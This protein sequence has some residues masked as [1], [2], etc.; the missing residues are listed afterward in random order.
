MNVFQLHKNIMSDYKAYI[1]SFV[2]ISNDRIKDRVTNE[3]T[4][5]KLW[6][7]PLIQ[8]NPSFRQGKSLKNL[9]E[10]GLMH[11]ELNNVFSGYTLYD[12]QVEAL[13]IGAS[14]KDFIV[15]SGTGSGKS[16]TYISTIFDHL[17]KTGS[18]GQGVK[19]VIVYPMNALINSQFGEFEKFAERYKKN[20]N[21][22]FP[23]K[24][25]KYTGQESADEKRGTIENPPD[26][27]LTNYVMLELLLTRNSEEKLR[28]N[29]F[30]HLKYLVFDELHTYR[31]RQGSDVA[32]L[33]RKLQS[34]CSSVPICIG[35]SATMASGN[36]WQDQQELIAQV[37]NRFFAKPFTT[38]QIIGE[39][40]DKVTTGISNHNAVAN[41]LR[42][43]QSFSSIND[44]ITN[45]LSIL[46]ESNIILS[47]R[48]D[49]YFRAKPETIGSIVSRLTEITDIDTDN[50]ENYF[51]KYL[52]ELEIFNYQQA[53]QN[54]KSFFPF[55]IHQF[56][57]QTGSVYATL[58]A[59]SYRAVELD[60]VA[61]TSPDKGAK[62][63]YQIVFSRITGVDLY[64][65]E[66]D[67]VSNSYKTRIFNTFV[68]DEKLDDVGYLVIQDPAKEPF[69]NSTDDLEKLP[70]NWIEYD[71]NGTPRVKKNY[72]QRLPQQTY[73]N[74]YGQ[75]SER[76]KNGYIEVWFIPFKSNIDFTSGTVYD[77][78]TRENTMYSSLG[79][80]GRSTSTNI[81]VFSMIRQMNAI[82]MEKAI[83]KVLSFTDNRQD[84]A[85]QSGHFNDFIR[86]G[87]LRSAIWKAISIHGK[88]DASDI[89]DKTFDQL[90]LD[91]NELSRRPAD[92]GTYVYDQNVNMI[93]L[94]LKY[95]IISDLKRG[96]RVILPN[97]EQ[98]ALLEIDY[99]DL[100]RVIN[101]AFWDNHPELNALTIDN[102]RIL[103]FQLL[104]AFRKSS[105]IDFQFL[106]PVELENNRQKLKDNLKPGWLFSEDEE[107]G[108]SVKIRIRKSNN[109]GK[110]RISIS[111]AASGSTIGRFIKNIL[112]KAINKR[113]YSKSEYEDFAELLFDFLCNT[114]LFVRDDRSVDVPLYQLN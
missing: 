30:D 70:E 113:F 50:C 88:S 80:E 96:W 11:S 26:V 4:E 21:K 3:L 91:V 89:V 76:P 68:D 81:L 5:G 84:T 15:V 64:C 95:K 53:Q 31:G 94:A 104:D 38:S 19:A 54:K 33:I 25:S 39:Y 101:N 23:F 59:F 24:V 78:R 8:F 42:N 102:R 61:R 35:T 108:H 67:K 73:V 65:V 37:A 43:V 32:I 92:P 71:K 99:K 82:G 66:Y 13:T 87:Q 6:P 40:L 47:L 93:K 18:W 22:E 29:I 77:S 48:G 107:L 58:E 52:N 45:P 111:T 49:R 62:P 63:F 86:V 1:Q 90:K 72:K 74:E 60:A 97:L 14:G 10:E 36:T 44:L 20:T 106:T 41:S 9:T 114:G 110:K 7:Q 17:F 69:W 34:Q 103:I 56:I 75:Q 83:Q 85:L 51:L 98:C 2:T 12:H 16:L 109:A 79:V 112:A 28:K 46:L 100:D 57:N 105:A 55:K 27:L